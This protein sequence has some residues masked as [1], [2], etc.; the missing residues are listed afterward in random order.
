MAAAPAARRFSSSSRLSP[1][2]LP[3][4]PGELRVCLFQIR[5]GSARRACGVAT[6]IFLAAPE[7]ELQV[8]PVVG[9]EALGE[10][11]FQHGDEVAQLPSGLRRGKRAEGMMMFLTCAASLATVEQSSAE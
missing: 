4:R 10:H 8:A 2:L 6:P 9:R 7:I 11:L 1:P 3:G 5:L